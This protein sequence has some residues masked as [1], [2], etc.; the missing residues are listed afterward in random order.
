MNLCYNHDLLIHVLTYRVAPL[1]QVQCNSFIANVYTTYGYNNR[2]IKFTYII[3]VTA[4]WCQCGWTNTYRYEHLRTNA[5]FANIRSLSSRVMVC[6]PRSFT[7]L[8]EDSICFT[9]VRAYIYAHGCGKL[10]DF[11][12]ALIMHKKSH[13]NCSRR[14][15]NGMTKTDV[16]L[17]RQL[18]KLWIRRATYLCAPYKLQ[19]KHIWYIKFPPSV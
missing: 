10:I 11:N 16:L 15:S 13:R 5:Y 19:R 3:Y 9:N 8:I 7:N 17:T 18:I 14:C 2:N 1:I 12:M 6:V 4:N